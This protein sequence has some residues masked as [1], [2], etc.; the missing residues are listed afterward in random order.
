MSTEN[1]CDTFWGRIYI[2][3]PVN[4]AEQIIREFCMS[5]FCVNITENKYIYTGGEETGICV[6]I[7]NYPRF[8]KKRLFLEQETRRLAKALL[9]GMHQGSYTVMFPDETEYFDRR[10]EFNK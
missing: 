3:G 9:D 1:T 4:V 5:G 6:E 8:P 7:I 10:D 2:A